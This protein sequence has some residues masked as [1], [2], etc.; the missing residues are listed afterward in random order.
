MISVNSWAFKLLNAYL[1]IRF[2]L[3][4]HEVLFDLNGSE[5]LLKKDQSVLFIANHSTW[6]DG[7]FIYALYKKLGLKKEFKVVMLESELKKFSFLRHWGAVGVIP[8]DKIHNDQVIS[9]LQGCCVSFFPQGQM[10]PQSQRPLIFRSGIESVIQKLHPTQ[11]MCVALHIEPFQS[12]KPT[13][14]I[15]VGAIIS[16]ETFKTYQEMERLVETNLNETA[17]NWTKQIY[18]TRSTLQWKS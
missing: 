10:Y 17:L 5:S 13:A 12:V 11:I 8:R 4:F 9:G 3:S 16:S 2:R 1:A 15:K 14:L 7:F 6:W 18:S